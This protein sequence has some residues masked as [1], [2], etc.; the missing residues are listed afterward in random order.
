MSNIKLNIDCKYLGP[1]AS[2]WHFSASANISYAT[3]VGTL[4][5][6]FRTTKIDNQVLLPMGSAG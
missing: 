4:T 1:Q 6:D 2:E 3:D 5:D